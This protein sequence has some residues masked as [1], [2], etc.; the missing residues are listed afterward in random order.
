VGIT[1]AVGLLWVVVV[2]A[3]RWIVGDESLERLAAQNDVRTTLLQ[4]LAGVA[5]LVGTYFTFRQFYTAREAQITER[6][7]RAIDHLGHTQLDVRLGGIYALERIGRDS[8]ADRA[9]IGEVLSAFVRSHSPWPPSL[10]GQYRA[11][12]PMDEIPDLQ[13]RAPDVQAALTVLGRG[14]F[15][16]PR[17]EDDRLDLK[18]V[19]LR[20]AYLVGAHLET[21]N[22]YGAHLEGAVLVDA[23]L[24]NTYLSDAGLEGSR[25]HNAHLEGAM[26]SDDTTWPIG[27]EWRE[28]GVS[29]VTDQEDEGSATWRGWRD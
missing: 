4:A 11:A 13:V 27:F 1:G 28:A 8:S 20:N 12:A 9:T 2:A 3:P 10:P 5:L 23:H 22:L 17:R 24:E 29:L 6:Y 25:L 16:P 15:A 26:A 21:A 19:D 7:T 18:A 14:D